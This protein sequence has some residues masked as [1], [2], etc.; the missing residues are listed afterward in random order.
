MELDDI[1]NGEWIAIIGLIL[2]FTGV[3]TIPGGIMILTGA[4]IQIRDSRKED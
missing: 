3:G 4:F 1:D 2:L